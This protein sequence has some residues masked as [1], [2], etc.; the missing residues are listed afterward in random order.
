M[1][2]GLTTWQHNYCYWILDKD[3]D[4]IASHRL[5]ARRVKQDRVL[6]YA[7]RV[8]R[9]GALSEAFEGTDALY[10]DSIVGCSLVQLYQH[11]DLILLGYLEIQMT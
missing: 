7:V 6:T 3:G 4:S 11:L 10:P 8:N 5:G 9:L 1:P 2:R